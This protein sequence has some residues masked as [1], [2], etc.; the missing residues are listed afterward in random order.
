MRD[1]IVAAREAGRLVAAEHAVSD[2]PGDA[3]G[4]RRSTDLFDWQDDT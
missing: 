1:F 3:T 2:G 4:A